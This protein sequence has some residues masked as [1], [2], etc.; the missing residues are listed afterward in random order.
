MQAQSLSQ[1]DPLEDD[2]ATLSRIP[3][4]FSPQCL[5]ESDTTEATQHPPMHIAIFTNISSFPM[6]SYEIL[7]IKIP[8]IVNLFGSLRIVLGIESL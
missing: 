7:K 8:V 4:G 1:E 3:V 6:V 2:M 5:A